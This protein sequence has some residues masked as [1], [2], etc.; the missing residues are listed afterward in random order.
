[1]TMAEAGSPKSP[2][3]E[4]GKVPP[5]A[6]PRTP[7]HRPL[8]GA[9]T[10]PAR[11]PKAP[12]PPRASRVDAGE[13]GSSAARSKFEKLEPESIESGPITRLERERARERE[14]PPRSGTS[15]VDGKSDETEAIA[16][17]FQRALAKL[18]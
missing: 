12:L 1:M 17:N 5:R 15:S 16:N 7:S 3:P 4:G 13:A 2:R 6:E 11:T 8:A 10:I 14:A 18:Q 9:H